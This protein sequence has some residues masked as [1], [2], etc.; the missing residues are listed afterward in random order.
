MYFAIFIKFCYYF[1]PPPPQTHTHA[2]SYVVISKNFLNMYEYTN[3]FFYPSCAITVQCLE[4]FKGVILWRTWEVW[5]DCV[6]EQY[7]IL[8]HWVPEFP[9]NHVVFCLGSLETVSTCVQSCFPSCIVHVGCW[10]ERRLGMDHYSTV[11]FLQWRGTSCIRIHSTNRFSAL[12]SICWTCFCSVKV[13]KGRIRRDGEM[14]LQKNPFKKHITNVIREF[15]HFL[16]LHN[17]QREW[18]T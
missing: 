3:I 2:R 12:L 1:N 16:L 5:L 8:Y 18:I 11:F 13:R 14:D 15:Y 17:G 10:L 9:N 6:L 7:K 4:V